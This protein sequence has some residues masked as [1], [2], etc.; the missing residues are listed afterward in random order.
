MAKAL[1]SV[2]WWRQHVYSGTPAQF[3]QTVRERV[4][5]AYLTHG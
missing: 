5:Q 3:E 2:H 4:D 1:S